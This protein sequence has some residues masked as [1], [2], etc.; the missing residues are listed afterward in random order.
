M[1]GQA[2]RKGQ[3]PSFHR[4]PSTAPVNASQGPMPAPNLRA[5]R[6]RGAAS[7]HS[8][9]DTFLSRGIGAGQEL[10]TEAGAQ[11]PSGPVIGQGSTGQDSV[12]SW[13]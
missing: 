7:Y 5:P 1:Q 4:R 8:V 12:G 3:W 2:Q 10:L 9:V 6:F 13:V 11:L